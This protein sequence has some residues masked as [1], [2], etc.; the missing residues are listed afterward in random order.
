[1]QGANNG[2]A[3][4]MKEKVLF[5]KWGKFSLINDSISNILRSEFP[6]C[7]TEVVDLSQE[8][9]KQ[10][11][12][13]DY[14]RNITSFVAEYGMDFVKGRK[15]RHPRNLISWFRNTSY[16]ASLM[17]AFIQRR[18]AG[19]KYKFTFQTQTL[20][21]GKIKGTP[22]FIYTDHTTRTNL[23]YPDIDPREYI[24]SEEFIEGIERKIYDDADMIFVCGSLVRH[25]LVSQYDIPDEKVRVVYAG[26]NIPEDGGANKGGNYAGKNILFVG[27]EWYRKGG[28]MALEVFGKVLEKHKDA[29]LTIIGCSPEEADHP[30]CRVL[31]KMPK[32]ELPRHYNDAALFFLPTL[33]EPFG[34]VFIEAMHYRLPI[35]ANNIGSIP[36]MVIPG[37][38]GCLC[39]NT[40]DEYA[41]AI[42]GLLDDPGRCEQMGENGF[43][44]AESRFRWEIVG[45]EMKAAMLGLI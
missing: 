6:E 5:L 22:H 37:H 33:R 40:V 31:G 25:S 29:T 11:G 17:N 42:C 8:W 39:K 27:I 43:R 12:V 4:I 44:Y 30:N 21:N 28:P 15:K 45:K 1:M 14:V 38:N 18:A 3:I 23:L 32:E 35:V 20:F 41:D 19:G 9:V 34:I 7:E 2:L 24:R 13:L 36:D 10:L 16:M 26:C